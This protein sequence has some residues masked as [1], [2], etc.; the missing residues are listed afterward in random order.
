MDPLTATIPRTGTYGDMPFPVTLMHV[1]PLTTVPTEALPPLRINAIDYVKNEWITLEEGQMFCQIFKEALLRQERKVQFSVKG[2]ELGALFFDEA[3]CKLYGDF[4]Q[5]VVDIEK[6]DLIGLEDMKEMHRLYY[7]NRPLSD[8][9]ISNIDPILEY[10]EPLEGEDFDDDR[11]SV[12]TMMRTIM[13]I[14][15]N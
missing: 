4:P 14:K 10:D 3:I 1:L 7:F 5:E 15:T 9:I 11:K 8:K 12:P 2:L 13:V 6:V